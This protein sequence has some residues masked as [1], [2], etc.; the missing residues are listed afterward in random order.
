M[1][2]YEEKKQARIDPYKEH[3]VNYGETGVIIKWS[4]KWKYL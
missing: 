1:N 3:A 2:R 4:M